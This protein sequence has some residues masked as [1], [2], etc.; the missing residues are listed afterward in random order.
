MNNNFKYD[1][2]GDL[3]YQGKYHYS[4]LEGKTKNGYTSDIIFI[5]RE[6]IQKENGD[7]I[8]GEVVDFVYGGF[9]SFNNN[10]AYDYI[11]N[12]IKKYEEAENE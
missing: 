6:P 12:A 5:F 3:Y 1:S 10:I 7:V 4:L 9:N 8:N 11:E 2:Q